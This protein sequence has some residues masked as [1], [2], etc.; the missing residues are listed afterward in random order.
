MDYGG[1]AESLLPVEITDSVIDH[2]RDDYP[3]LFACALA[4]RAWLPRARFHI[5]RRVVAMDVAGYDRLAHLS[6]AN[7]DIAYAIVHL[8]IIKGSQLRRTNVDREWPTIL[9]KLSRLED[10][11]VSQ[12]SASELP[13]EVVQDLPKY[14]SH[15]KTLRLQGVHAWRPW[16][17]D[18]PRLLCACS[19]LSV[20]YLD[21][22]WWLDPPEEFITLPTLHPDGPL[23]PAVAAS[24]PSRTVPLEA[25]CYS[26]CQ[27]HVAAWLMR[28]PLLAGLRRLQ[29]LWAPNSQI[30]RI[31]HGFLR[32]AGTS[33][34]ELCL[35]LDSV[36]FAFL[37]PTSTRQL[38]LERNPC[39]VSVHIRSA[40]VDPSTAHTTL[41]MLR[42]IML[43][44]QNVHA[45]NCPIQ[46]LTVSLAREEFIFES[47][48]S[49][50]P[51]GGRLTATR[52]WRRIDDVLTKLARK[53]SELTFTCN[54]LDHSSDNVDEWASDAVDDVLHFVPQLR[55]TDCEIR[56]VCGIRWSDDISSGMPLGG[57]FVGEFLERRFERRSRV[58]HKE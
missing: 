44:L 29:C 48:D 12:W 11:S 43:V 31:T 45:N 33:L 37:V 56:V 30:M 4:C 50:G 41:Y 19:E 52:V 51:H 21:S 1:H 55:A 3:S 42:N 36:P 25:L 53:D 46:H 28:S 38:N 8:S 49:H 14:F 32:A 22:I 10:L 47:I 20:L 7:Q 17:P 13:E 15:I 2:L 54:I 5:F 35:V 6:N 23:P 26:Q 40:N 58:L 27:E 57:M 18:F 24:M 39:L 9:S 34:E 16:K